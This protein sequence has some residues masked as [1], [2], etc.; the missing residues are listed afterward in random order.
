M[1]SHPSLPYQTAN[2]HPIVPYQRIPIEAFHYDDGYL[3]ISILNVMLYKK[4]HYILLL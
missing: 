2:S 1:L 4:C 3:F